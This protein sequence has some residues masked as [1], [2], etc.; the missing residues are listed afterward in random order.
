MGTTEWIDNGDG[1]Y[2]LTARIF[3]PRC[4]VCHEW[5]EWLPCKNQQTGEYQELPVC[6]ACRYFVQP[7]GRQTRLP[8][9]YQQFRIV[10]DDGETDAA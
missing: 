7:D 8:D 3:A 9:D 10:I 2:T 4:E 5:M 6:W 1:T